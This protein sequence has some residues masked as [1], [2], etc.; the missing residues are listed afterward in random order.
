MGASQCAIWAL[1]VGAI[2]RVLS[3][4]AIYLG[5]FWALSRH[6]MLACYLGGI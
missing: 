2:W 5:A 6:A 1:P 4:W 3:I